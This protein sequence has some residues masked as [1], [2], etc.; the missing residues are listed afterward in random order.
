MILR[1][2]HWVLCQKGGVC[3]VKLLSRLQVQLTR[4]TCNLALPRYSLPSL[5]VPICDAL[6]FSACIVCV[7]TIQ[8]QDPNFQEAVK[9]NVMTAADT[10]QKT[11][12]A[13]YQALGKQ[14]SVHTGVQLPGSTSRSYSQLGTSSRTESDY[15]DFW[16]ENGVGENKQAE[17]ASF[18]GQ[19]QARSSSASGNK[20]ASATGKGGNADEWE[21]W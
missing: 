21:S 14:V 19:Q 10:V 5:F 9:R 3:L 6:G 4:I 1:M 15:D 17:N 8:L 11:S 20:S 16:A 18:A 2:I 13:G 12:Y 7:L